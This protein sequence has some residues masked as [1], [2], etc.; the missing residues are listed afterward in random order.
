MYGDVRPRAAALLLPAELWPPPPRA[1]RGN[2]NSDELL[3][4]SGA[5]RPAADGWHSGYHKV[6]GAAAARCG[7]GR[8]GVWRGGRWVT[9]RTPQN[10][11]LVA[12]GTE[13]SAVT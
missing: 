10:R 4:C 3:Q 5:W 6:T 2:L 1:A 11:P 7:R 13:P 8:T 12:D 9:Q